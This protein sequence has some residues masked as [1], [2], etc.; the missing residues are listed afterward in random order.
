ML[1]LFFFL[2]L[3]SLLLMQ[4]RMRRVADACG[5]AIRLALT[6]WSVKLP[7]DGALAPAVTPEDLE[8]HFRKMKPTNWFNKYIFP[9]RAEK[10]DSNMDSLWG[11]V[12]S[13]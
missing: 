2:A 12:P 9:T 10:P 8:K 7:E 3:H 1:V 5:D 6:K 13:A 4:L 11:Y